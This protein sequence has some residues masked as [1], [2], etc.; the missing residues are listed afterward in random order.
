[1]SLQDKVAFACMYLDDNQLYNYVRQQTADV[2]KK[3]YI[4]GLFLTGLSAT[5]IKLLTNF[6]NEVSELRNIM[7]FLLPRTV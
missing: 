3:G 6:V 7:M 2:V 1:M 5:G 4:L